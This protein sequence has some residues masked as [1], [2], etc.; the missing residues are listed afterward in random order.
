MFRNDTTPRN[1]PRSR[2]RLGRDP[3]ESPRSSDERLADPGEWDGLPLLVTDSDSDSEHSDT[4]SVISSD[5]DSD[6]NDLE[7]FFVTNRFV[8][9]VSSKDSFFN[10]ISS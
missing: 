8:D 7:V 1:G 4:P 5:I 6:D 10:F 9:F 2:Y 3:D